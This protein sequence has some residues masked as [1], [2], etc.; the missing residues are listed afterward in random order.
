MI[1]IIIMDKE[2]CLFFVKEDSTANKLKEV[3]YKSHYSNKKLGYRV[4]KD[5]YVLISRKWDEAF[6]LEGGVVDSDMFYIPETGYTDTGGC[7]YEFDLSSVEYRNKCIFLGTIH[8]VY[9]HAITDALKRLW[10]LNTEFGRKLIKDSSVDLVYIT[11]CNGNMPQWHL[12]IFELAGVDVSRLKHIRNTTKYNEIIIPDNSLFKENGML[13]YSNEYRE[14]IEKIKDNVRSTTYFESAPSYDLYYTRTA[15]K[16]ASRREIGEKSIE[17]LFKKRGFQVFSPET[18]PLE[19]Q[20]SLLIKCNRFAATEG[21]CSHASVFCNSSAE[22]I[23]LR[24]VNNVNWYSPMISD[25]VGNRTVFVDANHSVMANKKAPVVGPFYLYVTKEL[26]RFWGLKS[27]AVPLIFR[28][29]YWNYRCF[30]PI[31]RE[32]YRLR[33]GIGLRRKL[34]TFISPVFDHLH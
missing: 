20:I 33:A 22:V 18:L 2:K 31:R 13:C 34:R 7:S 25:F 9:G 6:H 11:S 8:P 23:I 3:C 5:G 10:F 26:S 12:K 30:F 21:S 16:D 4:I 32:Y 24:K 29:S 14:I 15:L 28:P 1:F 17:K 27:F 19:E